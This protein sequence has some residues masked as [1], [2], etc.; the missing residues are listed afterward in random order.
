MAW[1]YIG[2]TRKF[3]HGHQVAQKGWTHLCLMQDLLLQLRIQYGYVHIASILVY[4]RTNTIQDVCMYYTYNTA[5][6]NVL[7]TF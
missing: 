1:Y 7:Y 6:K 3:L 5:H 4:V 2:Q